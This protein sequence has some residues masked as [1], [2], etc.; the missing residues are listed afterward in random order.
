MGEG[1]EVGFGEWVG[2][3]AGRGGRGAGWV[4]VVFGTR[5][6]ALGQVRIGGVV[7]CQC[8]GTSLP[9]ELCGW[10]ISTRGQEAAGEVGCTSRVQSVRCCCCF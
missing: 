9:T 6:A 1:R 7:G 10:V 4:G 2:A 5:L 8:V 3:G